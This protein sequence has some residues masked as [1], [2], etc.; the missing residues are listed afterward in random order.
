[1]HNL[2]NIRYT[3]NE[4]ANHTHSLERIERN[5]HLPAI[6]H[7][8]RQH[9]TQRESAI[10]P[11]TRIKALQNINISFIFFSGFRS[12]QRSQSFMS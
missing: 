2:L 9:K 6:V 5:R 1:M 8:I 10:Q 12:S 3:D 7:I 11:G 4:C